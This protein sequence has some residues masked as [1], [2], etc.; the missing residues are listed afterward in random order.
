[1]ASRQALAA[2]AELR[3][4]LLSVS[5]DFADHARKLAAELFSAYGSRAAS[6]TDL[7]T[8]W[9]IQVSRSARDLR[10]VLDRIQRLVNDHAEVVYR[11]RM[12]VKHGAG[13]TGHERDNC[14]AVS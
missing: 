2:A 6:P 12:A 5:N 7:P 8:G 11:H 9:E 14:N 1:M 3:S 10:E 13:V 4:V